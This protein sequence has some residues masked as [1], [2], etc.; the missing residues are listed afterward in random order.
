MW[1]WNIISHISFTFIIFTRLVYLVY[2]DLI[3]DKYK[4]QKTNYSLILCL[5]LIFVAHFLPESKLNLIPIY[6]QITT[7]LEYKSFTGTFLIFSWLVLSFYL[8]KHA[9]SKNNFLRISNRPFSIGVAGDSASGKNTFI[10]SIEDLFGK[11]SVTKVSGDNYHL[12]DRN[13]PVWSMLT[14]LNPMSNNLE[15]FT[16]DIFKLINSETIF[17]RKYDHKEG[18]LSKEIKIKANDMVFVSGLHALYVPLLRDLFD[19]KI[20]LNMDEDL[21][22]YFKFKRDVNERGH[23]LEKVKE[24]FEQR[25]KDSDLFIKPQMQFADLIF[26]LEPAINKI[27]LNKKVYKDKIPSNLL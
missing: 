16:N 25:T 7:F 11:H 10:D 26:T 6:A 13:K 8:W 3:N 15:K 27:F 17:A 18:I 22:R 19:L 23:D 21:R 5:S 1:Y 4:D 24:I 14:H 9:I 20:Y 2:S 12:W